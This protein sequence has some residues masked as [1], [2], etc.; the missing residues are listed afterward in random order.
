MKKKGRTSKV[1]YLGIFVTISVIILAGMNMKTIINNDGVMKV[2]KKAGAN[3]A[4]IED[5]LE[6]YTFT[7]DKA[8]IGVMGSITD[9]SNTLME[10]KLK[11]ADANKTVTFDVPDGYYTQ[12]NIDATDVYNA[13]ADLALVGNAEKADV[14]TGKTFTNKTEMGLT[15]TMPDNKAVKKTLS[16]SQ[17][18]TIPAGYHNGSGVVKVDPKKLTFK[19]TTREAK[20][21]MGEYNTFRYLDTTQVP[22]SKSGIYE[23]TATDIETCIA[24]GTDLDMGVTNSYRYVNMKPV[25]NFAVS[26]EINDMYLRYTNVYGEAYFSKDYSKIK[27]SGS[28]RSIVYIYKV[29]F[30]GN[31]PV[32]ILLDTVYPTSTER[33]FRTIQRWEN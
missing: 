15:G 18:Y 26:S 23:P 6:N 29:I 32:G 9:Y 11:A 8:G 12:V 10:L 28:A 20:K 21:D 17:T 31:D 25:Y 1:I 3:D 19:A 13:G 27:L 22:N 30:V 16:P 24:N 33:E 4:A 5:V 14:L 2:A 7:S